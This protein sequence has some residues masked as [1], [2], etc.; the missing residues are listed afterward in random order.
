MIANI[1]IFDPDTHVY[2][3]CLGRMVARADL[4]RWASEGRQATSWGY[5]TAQEAEAKRTGV[6]DHA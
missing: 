4:A 5:L 1:H 3:Y 2:D 6:Y